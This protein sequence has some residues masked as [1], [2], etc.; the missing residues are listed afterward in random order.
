[1]FRGERVRAQELIRHTFD[2]EVAPGVPAEHAE[3]GAG[4]APAEPGR[5]TVQAAAPAAD[6]GGGGRAASGDGRRAGAD[7]VSPTAS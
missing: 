1:M 4:E 3:S 5:G 2:W 7:G 6:D